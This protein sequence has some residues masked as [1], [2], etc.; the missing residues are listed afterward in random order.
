MFEIDNK[1]A[2]ANVSRTVRFTDELFEELN[3]VADS[4]NISFN[5]LVLQ[6]CDFALRHNSNSA[7]SRRKNEYIVTKK[8]GKSNL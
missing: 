4:H 1:F 7:S 8:K 5:L 3:T 6:C 2:N